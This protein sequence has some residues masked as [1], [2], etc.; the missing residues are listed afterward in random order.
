[1]FERIAQETEEDYQSLIKLLQSFGVEV[2]RTEIDPDQSK[3]FQNGQYHSPIMMTPRDWSIMIGNKFYAPASN[4][5]LTDNTCWN[6]IRGP[7]WPVTYPG[8]N[9]LEHWIQQELIEIHH[10]NQNVVHGNRPIMDKVLAQGNKVVYTDRDNLLQPQLMNAAMI[11]RVGRDLYWGSQSERQDLEQLRQ[12]RQRMF[13]E[14]RNHM[15]DTIGHSDGCYCPVKP[16]L[17]ISLADMPTYQDTFPDWEVVSLPN[18]SWTRV[19]PFL[20]LKEKNRGKWWVPGEELND[21]FTHY[22]ETWMDHWVGY[23]EESVFDVN[24]LVIDQHNVICNNENDAVFEAFH[25][26]GVT[27]HVC[28]FRHRYFWDGG[29]HCI[30]S[31]LHR[32]G[33]L[34]DH[35]PSRG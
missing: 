32:E 20:D 10:V 27:P 31:D 16:G 34:Q 22:V 30:T 28:N 19:Q 25:R 18:Q 2:V 24:M 12:D 21:E 13:P 23:V 33:T 5:D 7:D 3:Y 15:V 29:I 6:N 35:F 4:F 11:T 14:Y 17:I 26:H 8:W 9:H 1:V